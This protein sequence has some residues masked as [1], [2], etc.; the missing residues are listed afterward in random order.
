MHESTRRTP[1][2]NE[3]YYEA[4]R[5]IRPLMALVERIEDG[6]EYMEDFA[7]ACKKANARLADLSRETGPMRAAD[8]ALNA[9][10]AAVACAGS[11]AALSVETRDG[12]GASYV[13]PEVIIEGGELVASVKWLMSDLWSEWENP[14]AGYVEW[15]QQCQEKEVA[16]A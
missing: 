4:R 16:H 6:E 10:A 9:A 15:V 3:L 8:N 1:N 2:A 14:S 13:L 11:T 12:R 7:S 5:E